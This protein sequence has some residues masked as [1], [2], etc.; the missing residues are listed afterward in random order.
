MRIYHNYGNQDA[1][2]ISDSYNFVFPEEFKGA[3]CE[4]QSKMIVPK[5]VEVDVGCGNAFGGTNE[6]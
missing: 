3:V 5:D 6:E 2:I 1:E 4:V